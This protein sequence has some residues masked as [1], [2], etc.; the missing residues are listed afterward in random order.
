MW[1]FGDTCD[2]Y[3]TADLTA[4]Y[5]TVGAGVAIVPGAGRYGGNAMRL[6]PDGSLNRGVVSVG[7]T[8][9]TATAIA[10]FSIRVSA[11]TA[12]FG[13]A[14]IRDGSTD[15]A[16]IIFTIGTDG[17]ITAWHVN[18]LFAR[19]SPLQAIGGLSVEVVDATGPMIR[20]GVWHTVELSVKPHASAGTIA[21]KVDGRVGLTL[22]GIN[23]KGQ[24]AG[25]TYSMWNLGDYNGTPNYVD[26]DDI[27]VYDDV[28]TG[29]GVTSFLGHR[30]GEAL[31]ATGS[32]ATTAWTPS[33]GANY[34]CVDDATPDG[35]AT[36]V[37]ADD[38]KTDTYTHGPLTKITSGIAMAQVVTTAKLTG[39]GARAIR[40]VVRVAGTDY[41]GDD[42]QFLASDYA[43]VITPFAKNPA[44]DAEWSAAAVNAAEIGQ[45]TL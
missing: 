33:A 4:K 35:D 41:Q 45:K 19:P 6:T 15:C 17:A 34:Q 37:S 11:L 36:T 29:D 30:M 42:D 8:P 22:T 21:V 27:M 25:A 32:G 24:L 3:A 1:L 31:F 28:N 26:L 18:G 9:S 10:T 16:H 5:Q 2:H 7:V 40:G 44:T 14:E 12:A 38:G 43:V 13:F 23:T 39:S 20:A